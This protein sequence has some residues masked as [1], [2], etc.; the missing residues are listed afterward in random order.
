MISLPIL[1]VLNIV[2]STS[3]PVNRDRA[4]GPR[5]PT[6]AH[7]I[8]VTHTLLPPS[9]RSITRSKSCKHVYS[10]KVQQERIFAHVIGV[11][12]VPLNHSITAGNHEDKKP[13]QMSFPLFSLPCSILLFR[14]SKQT[15]DISASKCLHQ[16]LVLML[17]LNS[18]QYKMFSFLRRWR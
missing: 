16:V 1:C 3:C 5:S 4:Q 18:S 11:A 6:L 9:S 14:S 10:P 15:A 2:P 8:G 13:E 17:W 12:H 7:V